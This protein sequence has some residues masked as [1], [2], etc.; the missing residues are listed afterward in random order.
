MRLSDSG[1]R[2]PQYTKQKIV[3]VAANEMRHFGYKATNLADILKKSNVSKGAL[4]HHFANKQE[5]GYEVFE[6]VFMEE[7]LEVSR[8]MTS[9][10]APLDTFCHTLDAMV[11]QITD[12]E[13]QCGCPVNSISQEM[14]ADDEGFRQ[15][16]LKMYEKKKHVFKEMLI[17]CQQ[18]GQ[19]RQDVDVD[20][21]AIFLVSS[22][23]GMAS[24]GKASRDKELLRQVVAGIKTYVDGLKVQNK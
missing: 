3:E 5:L 2:D 19:V 24:I 22:M 21:A 15:R 14:S 11:D 6:S 12:D 10:E 16:T 8:Q 9:G 4:Y 1:M 23:Q 7:F 18:K 17:Q 13:L 20:T